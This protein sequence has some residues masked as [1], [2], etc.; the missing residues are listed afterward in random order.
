[1]AWAAGPLRWPWPLAGAAGAATGLTALALEPGQLVVD[2]LVA[3][4]VGVAG[5]LVERLQVVEQ[6]GVQLDLQAE[7]AAQAAGLAA[8]DRD[9]VELSF[10]V[11]R[12][13]RVRDTMSDSGDGV[14]GFGDTGGRAGVTPRARSR[15]ANPFPATTGPGAAAIDLVGGEV[16]IDVAARALGQRRRAV[17]CRPRVGD[18]LAAEGAGDGQLQVLGLQVHRARG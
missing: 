16:E 14:D 17:V 15:K 9:H 8:R 18:A 11:M 7:E 4:D 12:D 3:G 13:G 5:A 2:R 10:R 1:M 6:P